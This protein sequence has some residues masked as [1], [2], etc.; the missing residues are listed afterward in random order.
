MATGSVACIYHT[1]ASIVKQVQVQMLQSSTYKHTRAHIP[2]PFPFR[3][4]ASH[5]SFPHTSFSHTYATHTVRD[6]DPAIALHVISSIP[7]H[8]TQFSLLSLS[9][10]HF[11]L[12]IHSPSLFLSLAQAHEERWY[13]QKNSYI[14][15][16]LDSALQPDSFMR[17]ERL[18]FF[19]CLTKNIPA[20]FRNLGHQG[21]G[22]SAES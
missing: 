3:T 9:L 14:S 21:G 11:F 20:C 6:T 7:P 4:T 17:S 13:T 1:C 15:L 16:N 2:L 18:T 8:L 10:S 22:S 5:T 12:H 19:I